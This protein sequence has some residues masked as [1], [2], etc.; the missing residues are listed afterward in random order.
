MGGNAMVDGAHLLSL[1]A[2]VAAERE[3]QVKAWPDCEHL[4][5]GTGG[6]G[7]ETW[8]TIAKN[9]CDR[10]YR[11]GRLTHA[12]VAEEEF[13]EVLA[14]E[15]PKKL[16]IEIVQAMAVLAKWHADLCSRGAR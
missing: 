5:D 9:S 11:E 10:A 4:P 12:H 8:M 3:R 2:E 7:R 1:F 15:D 13:A 6:G 16:R 14:E